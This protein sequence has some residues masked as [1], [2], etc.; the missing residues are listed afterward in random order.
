MGIEVEVGDHRVLHPAAAEAARAA[1]DEAHAQAAVEERRLRARERQPVVGREDHERAL[2]EAGALE[3]GE[4]LLHAAVQRPRAGEEVRHVAADLGEVGQV[5]R[6]QRVALVV[7]RRGLEE[8]AVRL[9]EADGEEERLGQPALE[10]A[11][12][13]RRDGR[14]VVGV[15][16][17]EAVVAQDVGRL[18]D[19]CCSPMSSER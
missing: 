19:T 7:G 9:E 15:D 11:D 1:Q 17:V 4:D 13:Q 10:R 14:D 8:A 5:L 16:V 18:A 2:V 6:R 12:G 3:C